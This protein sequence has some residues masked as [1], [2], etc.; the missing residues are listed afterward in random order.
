MFGPCSDP[1]L[2]CLSSTPVL[3]IVASLCDP[4]VIALHY[5]CS[6]PAVSTIKPTSRD[7]LLADTIGDLIW[8][9]CYRLFRMFMPMRHQYRDNLPVPLMQSRIADFHMELGCKRFVVTRFW[10]WLAV[11]SLV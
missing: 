9:G 3:E 8:F 4:F 5:C 11:M 2:H 7:Y 1:R 6:A 10:Q